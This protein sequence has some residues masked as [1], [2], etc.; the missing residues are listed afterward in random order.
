MSASKVNITMSWKSVINL[1]PEVKSLEVFTPVVK[2]YGDANNLSKNNLRIQVNNSNLFTIEKLKSSLNKF[3]VIKIKDGVLNFGENSVNN[4]D[5]ILKSKEKIEFNGNFDFSKL[6]SRVIFDFAENSSDT[7][8]FIIQQKINQRNKIDYKG[9]LSISDNNFFVDGKA[10]FSSFLNLDEIFQ[11]INQ[12][13]SI[14]NKI[15]YYVN[16]PKTRN[17]INLDFEIEKVNFLKI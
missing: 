15:R 4:V 12:S 1:I 6:K 13:F 5:I 16:A 7:F 8:K 14:E 2:F 9:K 17:L 11:N 10:F 3:G